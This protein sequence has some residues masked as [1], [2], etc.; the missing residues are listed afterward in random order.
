MAKWGQQVQEGALSAQEAGSWKTP[1]SSQVAI[2]VGLEHCHSPTLSQEA[3]VLGMIILMA[4]LIGCWVTV[5]KISLRNIVVCGWS[6]SLP[7]K[8]YFAFW[9]LQLKYY[10]YIK[11]LIL[12][13]G[14]WSLWFK[15]IFHLY[16]LVMCHWVNYIHSISFAEKKCKLREHAYH[17][18]Y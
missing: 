2:L 7:Y 17:A 14:I 12:S 8:G 16:V 10:K 3:D 9:S 11:V 15:I 5:H 1:E 13:S 4:L 6:N 18:S